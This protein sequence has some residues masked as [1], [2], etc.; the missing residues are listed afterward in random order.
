MPDDD[1]PIVERVALEFAA[2]SGA[3]AAEELRERAES[4]QAI[5]D[6]LSAEAWHEIADAV[7][8][9]LPS[10]AAPAGD[11]VEIGSDP[12]QRREGNQGREE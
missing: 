1:D 5:G 2:R 11:V 12:P 7:E 4:A 10:S 9:L 3:K 6:T 8:R